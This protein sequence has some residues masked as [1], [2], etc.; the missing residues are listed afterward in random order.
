VGRADEFFV[1]A[2]VVV[3]HAAEVSCVGAAAVLLRSSTVAVG[4]VTG[5]REAGALR[6]ARV[7]RVLLGQRGEASARAMGDRGVVSEVSDG[8]VGRGWR[9][10]LVHVGVAIIVFLFALLFS[11][12]LIVGWR[13]VGLAVTVVIFIVVV[14]IMP[15][16]PASTPHDCAR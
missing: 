7:W 9:R 5:R 14:V 15:W 2:I 16:E 10:L 3:E 6:C 13:R 12:R 11:H 8:R 1:V 4:K